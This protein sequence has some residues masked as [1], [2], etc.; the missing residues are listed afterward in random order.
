[1]YAAAF[2]GRIV[3]KNII[4]WPAWYI[5]VHPPQFSSEVVTSPD[6]IFSKSRVWLYWKWLKLTWCWSPAEGCY[7]PGS[8][9]LPSPVQAPD[10]YRHQYKVLGVA[11]RTE[12]TAAKPPP[13]RKEEQKK[14][15]TWNLNIFDFC[16]LKT[17]CYL[18]TSYTWPVRVGCWS[19]HMD[20]SNLTS[21]NTMWV[22]KGS[23]Q[24]QQ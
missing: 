17:Q 6:D 12:D 7:R 10:N 16:D 5:L 9:S 23:S 2:S 24:H 21:N 8:L 1:M 22:Y 13:V 3:V 11:P 4:T 15:I 14:I 18:Q 20:V 19:Y